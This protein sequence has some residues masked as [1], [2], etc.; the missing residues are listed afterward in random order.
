MD[1]NSYRGDGWRLIHDGKKVLNLFYIESGNTE[2]IYTL[3]HGTEEECKSEIK[4]LG[5]TQDDQV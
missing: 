5:L 3:F 2:T 1:I 4:R